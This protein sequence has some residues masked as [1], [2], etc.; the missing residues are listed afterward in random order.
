MF[1]LVLICSSFMVSFATATPRHKTFFN[2]NLTDD[3]PSSILVLISS[4]VWI[5]AGNLPHLVKKGPPNFGNCL[6][7][8]SEM[9]NNLNFLDH[10]FNSFPFLSVGSIFF[11]KV[12]ASIY[13]TSAALHLSMWFASAITQTFFY[14]KIILPLILVLGCWV[15]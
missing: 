10:F 1:I 3:N 4:L 11:F 6:I 7:K 5:T 15:V 9:K 2:W 13:S 8:L 12:S 14:K